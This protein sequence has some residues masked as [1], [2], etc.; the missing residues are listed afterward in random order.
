M[1]FRKD[2]R[3]IVNEAQFSRLLPTFTLPLPP[4]GVPGVPE[5]LDRD[6]DEGRLE[7]V[8]AGVPLPREKESRVFKTTRMSRIPSDDRLGFIVR[9]YLR[10]EMS[11]E[12]ENNQLQQMW[13]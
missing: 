9:K 8:D 2:C 12:I 5:V 11:R 10:L 3:L 1:T 4:D 13:E 6:G 7:L